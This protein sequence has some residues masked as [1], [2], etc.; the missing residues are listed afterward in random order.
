MI[1]FGTYEGDNNYLVIRRTD[2]VMTIV[3][4]EK[5]NNEISQVASEILSKLLNYEF[6][7]KVRLTG[8]IAIR[9]DSIL[10]QFLLNNSDR[11]KY[12]NRDL[13]IAY[14]DITNALNIAIF[15]N[16]EIYN[17]IIPLF[18]NREQDY[19]DELSKKYS[20]DVLNFVINNRNFGRYLSKEDG[21]HETKVQMYAYEDDKI[22][23]IGKEI[24]P[25]D[26]LEESHTTKK[27]VKNK[28][29]LKYIY[30]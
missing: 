13:L 19:Y 11:T 30:D 14:E 12:I 20:E 22:T 26:S 29:R 16:N 24:V 1:K 2:L 6:E 8:A 27:K 17:E 5:S 18:R 23:L 7:N 4:E 28:H 25:T 15:E 21:E 10:G 3:F 9:K